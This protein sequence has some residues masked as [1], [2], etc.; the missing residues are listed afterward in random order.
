M[1]KVS[2]TILRA[3]SATRRGRGLLTLL[4]PQWA[5]N[6]LRMGAFIRSF[7]PALAKT[8]CAET[9]RTYPAFVPP[10]RKI[11]KI[12]PERRMTMTRT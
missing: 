6:A 12:R 2:R 10:R 7:I 8:V 11:N 5:E 4:I 1:R 9:L 3:W